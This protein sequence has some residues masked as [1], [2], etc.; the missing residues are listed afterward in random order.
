MDN[1]TEH[2]RPRYA[3]APVTIGLG[4]YLLVLVLFLVYVMIN[5]WPEIET[6]WPSGP[7]HASSQTFTAGSVASEQLEAE[8]SNETAKAFV[9]ATSDDR[10][11]RKDISLLGV[12]FR[13]HDEARMLLIVLLGGALGAMIHAIQSFIQFVGF[14]KFITS[15]VW[16]YVMRAPIGGTLALAFYF[17]LRGGLLAGG[18]AGVAEQLSIAG[19][20]SLSTLVGLFTEQAVKK[21][22][23]VFDTLFST[24]TTGSEEDGLYD[25]S[26][27]SPKIARLY[28]E[29]IDAGTIDKTLVVKGRNFAPDC[30]I[31]I[32]GTARDTEFRS[33]T[34]LV[35]HLDIT[36]L[37]VAG[38]KRIS[39]FDAFG[40]E[41]NSVSL[42]IKQP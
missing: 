18:G 36:D 38:S 1:N 2:L 30:E 13:I 37:G 42:T 24:R 22:S 10:R 19:V 35:T 34:E 21:L 16:W 25:P 20:A 3:S 11:W 28:P 5:A 39:V 26:V 14:R 41:S 33:E 29:T 32:D 17:A 15:W 6:G 40:I 31:H 9:T 27:S 12:S 23:D 4:I 8:P 7:V